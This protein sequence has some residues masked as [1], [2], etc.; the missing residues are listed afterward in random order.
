MCQKQ[1]HIKNCCPKFSSLVSTVGLEANGTGGGSGAGEDG[2]ENN[3]VFA[4]GYHVTVEIPVDPTGPVDGMCMNSLEAEFGEVE[5]VEMALSL[6]NTLLARME[7]NLGRDQFLDT[8]PNDVLFLQVVCTV[9]VSVHASFDRRLPVAGGTFQS[10]GLA[11]TGAQICT[12]GLG[13]LQSFGIDVSFLVPTRMGVKGMTHTHVTI[14]GALFLEISASGRHT[15]QIVYVASE[16]RSLIL[17]EKALLD[18]G[19]IPA[20]FPVAGMFGNDRSAQIEVETADVKAKCGCKVR[21]AVPPLPTAIPFKP[22]DANLVKF[23]KWFTEGYYG[24]SAFNICEHQEIPCI[25]GPYLVIKHKGGVEPELVAIHS[26]IQIPHHFK[27][28]VK[29]DLDRDL[30]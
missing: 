6:S 3:V 30:V 7:Y 5:E 4:F 29:E 28:K 22:V 18:L 14:L 13:F 15:K 20:E 27:K 23:E 2:G 19:V 8:K 17:S 24:A 11:D 21:T 9:L 1:G 25:A 16:A 12:A 26:P 10:K